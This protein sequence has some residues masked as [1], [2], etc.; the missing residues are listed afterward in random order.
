ME[1]WCC[2]SGREGCTSDCR[3]FWRARVM[4]ILPPGKGD[5]M[6]R[7]RSF[8]CRICKFNTS[9]AFDS[10]HKNVHNCSWFHIRWRQNIHYWVQKKFWCRHQENDRSSSMWELLLSKLCKSLTLH[11]VKGLSTVEEEM[12][13]AFIDLP[14][15]ECFMRTCAC[16]HVHANWHPGNDSNFHLL[17]QTLWHKIFLETTVGHTISCYI[18]NRISEERSDTCPFKSTS[19]SLCTFKVH[20]PDALRTRSTSQYCWRHQTCWWYYLVQPKLL[21]LWSRAAQPLYWVQGC[22][23]SSHSHVCVLSTT[24]ETFWEQNLLLTWWKGN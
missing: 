1:N 11:L 12:L 15:F 17:N 16:V 22:Y 2:L 13:L 8:L 14:V 6:T 7:L 5:K 20:A 23:K 21:D 9:A 3:L 19:F 24:Q 10:M 18:L 4:K